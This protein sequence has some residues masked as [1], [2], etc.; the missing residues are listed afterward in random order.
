MSDDAKLREPAWI[1]R[2]SKMGAAAESRRSKLKG[3]FG[4]GNT[5]RS[6]TSWSCTCGW[7]GEARELRLQPRTAAL[8]CPSCGE[9]GGLKAR[10]P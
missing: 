8:A 10:G 2:L 4:A 5:G 1:A 6:V 3:T 7:Q 9:A